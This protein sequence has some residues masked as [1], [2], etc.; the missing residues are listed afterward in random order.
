MRPTSKKLIDRIAGDAAKLHARKSRRAGAGRPGHQLGQRA[1][2]DITP[3]R[4]PVPG[5]A[6]GQG[7]RTA[8]ARVS[9]LVGSHVEG[10]LFGLIGEPHVNVL[11][12][13]MAL[14]AMQVLSS[15]LERI[16]LNSAME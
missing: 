8:E 4:R 16:G 12:L 15:R 5:A 7:A 3:G 9:A 10:R 11:K 6:R 2:P 1:R 14:D 13:N